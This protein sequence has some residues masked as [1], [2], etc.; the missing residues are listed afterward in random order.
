MH[1]WLDR[2]SIRS[3]II[4]MMVAVLLPVAALLAWVLHD[5]VRRARS[6]AYD[7]VRNLAA[8]TAVEL[9]RVLGLYESVLAQVSARPMVRALDPASC[10]LL[11]SENP[12]PSSDA[13]GFG[14][15]D[16]RGKSVCQYGPGLVPLARGSDRLEEAVAALSS[17]AFAASGVRVDDGRGRNLAA[18]SYPIRD[19]TGK[20]VGLL[21]MTID[22]ASLNH[23]LR[24]AVK[25][26]AVVTVTDRTK[27]VLLRST[28]PGDSVGSRLAPEEPGPWGMSDGL[29]LAK[30]SDGEPWLVASMTLPGVEWRV[31]AGL[32]E[33][34]VLADFRGAVR[35][36][37]AIGLGLCL[38]VMVLAWRLSAAISGPVAQ[39]QQAAGE[40]IA[41]KRLTG[42]RLSGPPEIRS[43]AQQFNRMLDA[44]ALS[45]ARREAVFA[46][47][48]DAILSVDENRIIVHANSA[49][50]RMFG[51]P[52]DQLIGVSLKRFVPELLRRGRAEQAA[53]FVEAPV[54]PPA[55][56]AKR[57]VTALRLD[58]VEFPCEAWVSRISI[59]GPAT[60]TAILRDISQRK[61]ADEDLRAGALKLQAAL[62]SMSDAV[63]ICD[64]DG[65]L[66]EINDAFASF[67]GFEKRS[68]CSRRLADYPEL[69]DLFDRAGCLEAL[70][71]WPLS[72]ALRGEAATN[73]EYLLRRRDTGAQRIGIY[74]YAPVLTDDGAIAG[75]VMTARDVSAMREVQ[76]DLES[77]HLALQRL[78]ASRDH[79]QEEERKRIA[80]ELHD[81]LQQRLAAIRMGL[82]LVTE[83]YS[84][85]QP[86]LSG[87]LAG[88]DGLAAEAVVS[89]R[90]IVN[91]LRPPM[92]EDLGLLPALEAM[93]SQFSQQSGIACD[94]DVAGGRT[95]E[96]LESP[97]VA[98]CLYRVVQEALNNV[99]KHSRA[100]AVR[101]QLG[102]VPA[103][104]ISLRLRDNGRGMES[105]NR[106]K[107]ESFGI[108]GMRERVRAHGGVMHID[109]MPGAGTVLHV[110]LPL[111][112]APSNACLFESDGEADSPD[113]AAE[114]R[115]D[116]KVLPRLL[117]RATDQTLQDVIDA[118][119]GNVAVID[120]HGTI[121]FVNREWRQ[122]AHKNGDPDASSVGPGASYL[123]VCRRSSLDD[124]SA[125]RV[126]RGLEAVLAET[127]TAFSCEY[128]CHSEIEKRWFRMHATRMIRGD[129]MVA[130]F[131]VRA[132]RHVLTRRDDSGPKVTPSSPAIVRS[133]KD[134][135]GLA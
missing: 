31:A 108:L 49:A 67:H 125:L 89:T 122:F 109:S 43:V 36:T 51:C 9:G 33:A 58:G 98:I 40:V 55:T 86:E 110:L 73:V 70:A 134:R 119:S 39:M 17:G 113:D 23:Q 21:V 14:V 18:L 111:A 7:Q 19:E 29:A 22:S 30:G 95:D 121:R 92:L 64:V 60:Y 132:E 124:L 42:A 84:A 13:L 72:R 46:S 71:Q 4:L 62:A 90:R 5:D 28:D 128:P 74:S 27:A 116:D 100:S 1:A 93:A 83:Q 94:V 48:L 47:A 68:D 99:A 87:L 130:H 88:I 34:A 133:P 32:P 54:V 80:R 2:L 120:K 102:N 127:R 10:E 63:C 65:R 97:A 45:E 57:D 103:N 41:G 104:S 50:A 66:V 26:H 44:L 112:G 38:L 77:S 114:A 107:P 53:V 37:I 96:L 35:R 59:D 78:I 115:L 56:P 11:L 24:T 85:G 106:R 52:L 135:H 131:L 20:N 101:I 15:W 16:A 126:L 117:G 123:E 75:A 6:G 118:I 3:R 81:D 105:V 8:G 129:V 25:G 76:L 91:D 79:V 69:L 61:K 12:S 82:R